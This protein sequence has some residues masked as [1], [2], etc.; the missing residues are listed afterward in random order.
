M[1][2][3]TEQ[4]DDFLRLAWD[5]GISV[6]F[7]L[8]HG[9]LR[10]IRSVEAEGVPLRNPDRLWKPLV[11]TPCGIHYHE[12]HLLDVAPTQN[13]G[14]CV[15]AEAIGLQTQK[16]EELDEYLCDILELPDD[17][18][19]R[20]LFEWELW[21]SE[22]QLDDHHFQGFA[23][24]YRFSS[25]GGREIYRIFDDATWEIGGAVEGNTLLLQGQLNPPVTHLKKGDYFTTACNYYGA[26]MQGVLGEPKRVSIQRLPRIATLQAFDFLAH[27][28]GVL[29]HYF[30][31]ASEVLSLVHKTRGEDRLHFLDELRRPLSSEFESHSKHILF[32]AT[33]QPATR[34]AVRNVWRC[35]YDFV[36]ERERQRAGIAASPVLPRVW[37]PQ[38]SGDEVQINGERFPRSRMLYY[39]ADKVL[40]QWAEMGVKEICTHSLWVSDYTVDRFLTKNEIGMHGD[41]T[42]SGICC[43]RVHEIDEHWGGVAALKY[44]VDKAHALNMQVQLW[45]ATHLSRRA[46]IFAEHP[47]WMIR[48][49]DD[50]PGCGGIGKDVIIPMNLNNPDCLEWEYN[51]LKAIYKATGIDGFFHDSYGNYTFLPM[52][53]NDPHLRGQQEAYEKLIYRLQIMGIKT[54]TAEGIG[55]FGTGHFGMNLMAGEK[56]GNYYNMLDWWLDDADMVYRLN[57]GIEAPVWPGREDEAREFAFRC[58]AFGGRFGFSQ[59]QNGLESWDGWLREQNQLLARIAPLQGTRALLPDGRGVLW[60]NDNY[61]LLFA[62]D[63]FCHSQSDVKKVTE[64]NGGGEHPVQIAY[65]QFSAC[66]GKVYRIETGYG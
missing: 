43:V 27:E 52:N 62:L 66:K 44:F 25:R 4:T 38:F 10:G 21:P 65:G 20:D 2:T 13:G 46:P 42:V 37:I 58:M 51:K 54:F 35:A 29:F 24:R 31:S 39:L 56:Q 59:Y 9:V 5:N 47:E 45:W 55:P 19:P 15:R 32:C 28:R 40:P 33:Q 34:E 61:H 26:E 12:F 11:T 6:S 63:E 8:Q 14:I 53:Y 36:H 17:A 50:Q 7:N 18:A 60:S 16:Q 57:I 1:I 41:L 3:N 49:R 48:S 22:L 23:Y 30:D 64:I